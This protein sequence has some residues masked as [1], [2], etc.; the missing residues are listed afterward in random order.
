MKLSVAMITY[1]HERFI[2]QA[3]ESILAQNVNF[4]YEI[5]IGEDRS[6]DGTRA[7]VKEFYRRHPDRIKLLLRD[8]NVGAMR[9]FIE[10][11]NACEGEYVAFLEGDDYWTA[12]DRLQKQVDYLDTHPDRAICCGRA[13]AVYESGTEKFEGRWDLVPPCPAGTYTVE[14]TLKSSFVLLCTTV[15]RREFV[16]LFPQWLLEMK[17]G[18]WPLCAMV[19]RHG[20]VE[21]MDEIM[22]AYRVHIGGTWSS[23]P[24]VTRL[25]EAARMLRALDKEFGYQYADVIREAMAT[26]YLD[27]AR[28]SRSKGRRVDTAKHVVHYIRNGGWRCPGSARAVAGLIT[29]GVIGCWYKVFSRAKSADQN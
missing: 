11:I 3:I 15:L 24:H 8:R 28:T 5:V 6:T 17:L 21:L 7:V 14:D 12:T 18:D 13:R 23:L 26:P 4:E 27:L 19:A 2:G 16:P 1:N 29:Y 25:N 22:A 10:T 9:N 20:K